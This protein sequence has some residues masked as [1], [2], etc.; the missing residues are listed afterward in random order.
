MEVA[1]VKCGAC[2]KQM[3]YTDD[4]KCIACEFGRLKSERLL[5]IQGLSR[6][7][8]NGSICESHLAFHIA[9]DTLV[10]V[11]YNPSNHR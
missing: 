1:I 11:K 10:K 7:V 6:I 9:K 8:N 2:K 5:L 4:K 3:I